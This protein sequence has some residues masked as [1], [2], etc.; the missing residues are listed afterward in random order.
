MSFQNFYKTKRGNAISDTLI[1]VIVLV[2]LG[3]FSVI[4]YKFLYEENAV[5]QADADFSSEGQNVSQELT[6]NFPSIFDN[7]FLFVFVMLTIGGIVTSFLVDTHPIFFFINI[8]LLICVFFVLIHLANTYDDT[9]QDTEFASFAASFP[10]MTWVMTHLL[11]LG[12]VIGFII[13]TALFMKLKG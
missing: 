5:I 11:P 4:G 2:V 7:L 10:Y 6:N 3:I 12:I 9:M 13:L 8:F 1:V